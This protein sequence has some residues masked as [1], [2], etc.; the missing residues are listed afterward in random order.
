M[1]ATTFLERLATLPARLRTT[2]QLEILTFEYNKRD[3]DIMA[4]LAQQCEG[5]NNRGLRMR[6]GRILQVRVEPAP[7]PRCPPPTNQR[8]KPGDRFRP[9]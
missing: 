5:I 2:P 1:E 9:G 8:V 4:L 3:P 7:P 6:S